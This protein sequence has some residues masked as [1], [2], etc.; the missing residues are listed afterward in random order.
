MC[1]NFEI[2]GLRIS[3]FTKIQ[4]FTKS[5]NFIKKK[6]FFEI[7]S[8]FRFFH[9]DPAG[10]MLICLL[11]FFCA[12]GIAFGFF[13]RNENTKAY[14]TVAINSAASKNY[15]Y[16]SP[17]KFAWWKILAEGLLVAVLIVAALDGLYIL[18]VNAMFNSAFGDV[19]GVIVH[20]GTTDLDQ[21]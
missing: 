6:F 17:L 11:N 20:E 7:F 16:R 18:C 19:M 9:I 12:A 4:I 10:I 15:Y 8:G 5:P 21:L 3:N 1:P 2:L 14:S 13:A